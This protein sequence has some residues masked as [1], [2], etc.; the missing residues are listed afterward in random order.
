[1]KNLKM[2]T[3][4]IMGNI[5]IGH[6]QKKKHNNTPRTK[7][8]K[9]RIAEDMKIRTAYSRKQG[10]KLLKGTAKQNITDK[11]IQRLIEKSRAVQTHLLYFC[12][13]AREAVVKE[14]PIAYGIYRKRCN[15]DDMQTQKKR[16]Q[17]WMKRHNKGTCTA[18]SVGVGKNG[19]FYIYFISTCADGLKVHDMAVSFAQYLRRKAYTPIA[20]TA[21]EKAPLQ[22]LMEKYCNDAIQGMEDLIQH[23]GLELFHLFRSGALFPYQHKT[24]RTAQATDILSH[25]CQPVSTKKI[26]INQTDN[27][28]S[29]ASTFLIEENK[30]MA[31]P[32]YDRDENPWQKYD[33]E[34]DEDTEDSEF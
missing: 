6:A 28:W 27:F 21:Y 31:T 8:E 20:L 29:M 11:N 16:I 25:Y 1:M 18:V 30:A 34:E 33:T 24:I 9:E 3:Y 14:Q 19:Y 26:A 4:H 5:C 22:Y 15:V 17:E 13:L 32:E 23:V 12:N 10:K 2:D 7:E